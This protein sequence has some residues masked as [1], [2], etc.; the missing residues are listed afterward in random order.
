MPFDAI[1]FDK[2]GTLVDFDRTWGPAAHD[3]MST[4]A[5]GD[6]GAFARLVD[7]S[8]FDLEA[9]TFGVDSPLLA[10][11]SA[12]YGP[13]WADALGR[14]DLPVLC[15]EMDD[16]FRAAALASLAPLGDPHRLACGLR[17][18]GLKLGIASND[19]EASVRAQA[20]RLG[21][22]ELMDFVAG[23]DSG[24]G[25]KP[26]PGMVTAFARHCGVAPG[27]IAMVGDTM[28]D[29]DAARAAGAVSIGV[30]SGPGHHDELRAHADH[31]IDHVELLPALL[32]RLAR[33][34]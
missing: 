11:S 8:R 26:L 32:D 29:V 16:L 1:L 13:L 15:R 30:L 3:V 14:L 19:A 5:A 9:M 7:V 22:A 20:G 23:Y 12:I 18:R 17:A 10:G 34:A 33:I 4:L 31:V 2:D 27:R 25:G 6:R 28:H 21:I 24:F